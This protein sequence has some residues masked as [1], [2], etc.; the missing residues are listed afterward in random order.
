[1]VCLSESRFLLLL[2]NVLNGR[3]VFDSSFK[4]VLFVQTFRLIAPLLLL[5][6][7]LQNDANV[8]T[9]SLPPSE[10]SVEVER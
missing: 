1:M 2:S 7:S 4:S 9:P 6:F 8:P 3:N 5:L 10:T